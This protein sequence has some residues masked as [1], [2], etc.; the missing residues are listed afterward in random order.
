[1]LRQEEDRYG[2]FE[3]IEDRNADGMLNSYRRRPLQGTNETIAQ[4]H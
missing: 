3:Q 2:Y 1:M 4:G